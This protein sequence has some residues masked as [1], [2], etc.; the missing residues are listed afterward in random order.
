MPNYVVPGTKPAIAQDGP[1]TCWATVYTT[2][3]AWRT[4]YQRGIR[5]SVA[6]V[7]KKYGEMYDAGLRSN[8]RPRG[9]PTAEFRAFLQ[10]ANMQHQPMMNLPVDEWER[11]LMTYGLLWIG[12]LNSLG[13]RRGL[14]SRIIEGVEGD[15]GNTSTYFLIID[16]DGGRRYR[17]RFDTFLAKYEGAIAG[18]KSEYFQIRHF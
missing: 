15:G 6:S 13:P 17:E 8:P 10:A 5:D 16:P 9:M 1:M 2:M 11:L 18:R 14:H 7:K 12:T 4:G 3:I